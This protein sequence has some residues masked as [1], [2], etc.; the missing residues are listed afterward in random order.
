MPMAGLR[1]QAP[2]GKHFRA[3]FRHGVGRARR[4]AS[5]RRIQHLQII[6]TVAH[7][8]TLGSWQ[9]VLPRDLRQ[10]AAFMKILMPETQIDRIPLPGEL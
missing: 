9:T 2:R 6:M 1:E 10:A 5:M 7:R 3:D 8:E 4:H